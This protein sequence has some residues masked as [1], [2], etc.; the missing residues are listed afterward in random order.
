MVVSLEKVHWWTH[1]YSDVS[2]WDSQWTSHLYWC[3]PPGLSHWSQHTPSG[4]THWR[5]YIPPGPI[6]WYQCTPPGPTHWSQHTI[7]LAHRSTH[8]PAG[9]PIH[10]FQF[11][12]SVDQSIFWSLITAFHYSYSLGMPIYNALS[13][14]I[15]NHI[16]S[17]HESILAAQCCSAHSW[18]VVTYNVRGLQYVWHCHPSF[19]VLGV[20]WHSCKTLLLYQATVPISIQSF[21]GL[22]EGWRR[23][24]SLWLADWRLPI[25]GCL[26]ECC[27]SQSHCTPGLVWRLRHIGQNHPWIVPWWGNKLLGG[28]NL[29]GLLEQRLSGS[30]H[31]VS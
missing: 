15:S 7:S 14:P 24:S 28:L 17:A 11:Q 8:I 22:K 30:L 16:L 4:P 12:I 6:H 19:W 25:E 31:W 10:V 3:A 27:P 20:I 2:A 21:P 23:Q 5:Q 9:Q 26:Q 29:L 1:H 18:L 13:P